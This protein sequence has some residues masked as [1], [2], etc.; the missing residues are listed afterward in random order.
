MIRRQ[1]S[2]AIAF[3]LALVCAT[4]AGAQQSSTVVL[5]SGERQ[6]GELIG[7]DGSTYRFRINGQ[8]RTFGISD[9]AAVEFNSSRTLTPAQQRQLTQGRP[10]VILKNGVVVNGRVSRIGSQG[11]ARQVGGIV[12]DTPSG[13][14]NLNPSDVAGIYVT[15]IASASGGA[16][17]AAAPA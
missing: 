9:V 5:Q 16:Q 17:P 3:G 11:F 8:D 7:F 2:L 6:S 14:R 4:A 10:F 1:V 13:A 12:V 15:N